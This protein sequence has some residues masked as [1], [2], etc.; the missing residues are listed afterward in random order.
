MNMA[1]PCQSIT[2]ATPPKQWHEKAAIQHYHNAIMIQDHKYSQHCYWKRRFAR[3][4]H[5]T[6]ATT[7]FHKTIAN[8]TTIQHHSKTATKMAW[9]SSWQQSAVRSP[10]IQKRDNN[11]YK[12]VAMPRPSI[13]IESP[14]KQWREKAAIQLYRNATTIQDQ[15]HSK[16]ATKMVWGSS[17]Q[18]S[19]VR[20]PI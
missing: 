12:N 10:V 19:A 20:N 3:H 18:P 13:T 17:W 2:I 9:G 11:N 8:A 7:E 15:H 5:H 1:M 6:N 14:P 4:K 16:T